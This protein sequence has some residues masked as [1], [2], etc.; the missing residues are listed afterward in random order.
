MDSACRN[1]DASNPLHYVIASECHGCKS[2]E[3]ATRFAKHIGTGCASYKLAGCAVK[4]LTATRLACCRNL[5]EH[6]PAGYPWHAAEA[7][8][9]KNRAAQIAGP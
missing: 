1:E 9:Q 4:L 5:E 8:S 3:L 7:I 6:I 2:Q